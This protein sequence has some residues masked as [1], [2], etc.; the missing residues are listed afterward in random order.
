MTH[1]VYQAGIIL[2]MLAFVL[3]LFA[4]MR[5]RKTFSGRFLLFC[6][7]FSLAAAFV[8]SRG[9]VYLFGG[10]M[11]RM[12]GFFSLNPY[13]YSVMGTLLGIVTGTAAAALLNGYSIRS[14][15][16]LITPATFCALAIARF[17]E[18]F[19]DFGWGSLVFDER[20]QFFP[21][22]IR[23]MY[24]QFH[25]AVFLFEGITA[26]LLVLS[27]PRVTEGKGERFVRTFCRFMLSQMF[28]ESLRAETLRIGFV[29][30]Q[31][32]E[33]AVFILVMILIVLKHQKK[34]FGICTAV[35]LGTVCI[36]AFCEF[37][38]DKISFIPA[39]AIYTLFSLALIACDV[40]LERFM[41]RLFSDR[42]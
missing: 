20:F 31:Q 42:T 9:N 30:V 7:L 13:D 21:L 29:R 23:D 22:C 24:D 12:R 32:V 15:L 4:Q 1:T 39:P 40:V 25:L 34:L 5:S 36:A 27:L 18:G 17:T 2:A 14:A 19:S 11:T 3:V 16:D 38:L 28:F 8:F 26:V 10:Y 37:A 6:C 35:H 33:C 41:H